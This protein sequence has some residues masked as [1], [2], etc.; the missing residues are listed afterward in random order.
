MNSKKN[1][2]K[3]ERRKKFNTHEMNC[4]RPK[5]QLFHPDGEVYTTYRED[6]QILMAHFCIVT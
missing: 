6:L 5:L 4:E 1:K 2:K 3:D